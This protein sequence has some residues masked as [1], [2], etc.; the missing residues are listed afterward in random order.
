[1]TQHI[2]SEWKILGPVDRT[3]F[4][5]DWTPDQNEPPYI[6]VWGNK[7]YDCSTDPMIE[8]HVPG[9]TSRIYMDKIVELLE[10]DSKW[11]VLVEGATIDRTW[12][13]HPYDPP[14]IY[15]F[16]NKWNDA[17]TEPTIEYHAPGAT[18]R[19]YVDN[20]VAELAETTDPWRV[21]IP[22]ATIDRTWRPNPYDQPYIYVFG[23][24][25]ND[26][27]TEVTIEYHALGA[28][29]RK[30]ITDIVAEL[31]ANYE[32]WQLSR[33]EIP[34]D[35]SWRP[36]PFASPQIYQWEN[37]GPIYTAPG[38]S[39]VILMKRDSAHDPEHIVYKYYIET[40][41]ED[42]IYKHQDKVFW[43]LNSELNYNKFDFSWQPTAE[44]FLHIN[45]FGNELSKDTGTYLI[46]GP[47]YILG[48]REINYVDNAEADLTTDIDMFYIN[49]GNDD[50]T[51]YEQLLA[52]FPRLQKTR[53]L[54]SWIE[55]I[56][57]CVRRATSKYVWILSSEVDYTDFKFDF[58]PS[59]WQKN[60]L[61]VFG[62]QWSHWG[63]IYLVNSETFANDSQYITQIEH[64]NN[65]NHVRSKRAKLTECLYDI[66]YID[67]G[68]LSESYDQLVQ[69]CPNSNIIVIKY[70]SD[71]LQT[72]TRWLETLQEYEIKQEHYVWV[73]SSIC[74]YTH[75]DFSWACDPYEREQLHVFASEYRGLREKFGDTFLLNLVE[76]YNERYILDDLA[77]Y[78]KMI[79]YVGYNSPTRLDHP[80]IVHDYDS[81][82]DA[83]KSSEFTWPYVEF[84]NRES[85]PEY[86]QPMIP[87]LWNSYETDVMISSTGASRIIVPKT[88]QDFIYNEVY[89][90]HNIKFLDE[91]TDS[92]PLDIVFFSNGESIADSNYQHLENII[93]TR[94]LPNRLVRVD[95]VEGRVASQHAAAHASTTA[96]YFLVNA[97]LKVNDEF[98]FSWQ[99]DRLQQ[100]KH[101]IFTATNPVNDL[102]YGHQAI[103]AN[104]KR[105][106]LNTEVKGLDFTMDSL[107][108][109][110]SRNSG[111][112]L[113]DTDDWTA[114][115]TAF[116]EV[117]KLNYYST[118]SSSSETRFRLN[119]W[120]TVGHGPYGASS[121]RG[122]Q[123]A[124]RYFDMVNGDLDELMKS[125]D[126]AWIREYYES[127]VAAQ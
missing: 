89:D 118:I 36:N 6:Y 12:H 28:T 66:V 48:H 9:A 45:A 67:H 31:P 100:P 52:R 76:F 93:K 79:S 109:V 103:V 55:T 84:V 29:D 41:L 121:I 82:T 105:L 11:T 5:F 37:N 60:M 16:G 59:T 21:I 114:Y 125:Y 49:R 23:N 54:N 73:C 101:Y 94:N 104:N 85:A 13:P 32:N 123:H 56:N 38:A 1:M 51:R 98:D 116:R 26:A 78:R 107:H 77:E 35:Y 57:R 25:W 65:I 120:L 20:I 40:N 19:K 33:S 124:T 106:T 83:I 117:I 72:L 122:A 63:N 2:K 50:G 80:V 92:Q 90:Y 110:V 71:Y 113:Y 119:A 46:N 4:N 69:K 53:F 15:V 126:W 127:L 68:N 75:F 3:K 27:T 44:N 58:Y 102:E 95:R 17:T 30:Y 112:A 62:T 87:I 97:K 81:Q 10:D 86:N 24:K 7:W 42:L 14:Y 108:D 22:G 18:D 43:A 8:Y 61:H 99:P 64:M 34:F 91:L 47:A 39:E 115:R 111:V 70:Q 74:D 96:W 88:A